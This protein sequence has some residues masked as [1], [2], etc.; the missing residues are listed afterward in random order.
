M[1]VKR[2]LK[3]RLYNPDYHKV[4][5]QKD[6]TIYSNM[7]SCYTMK[8]ARRLARRMGVGTEIERIYL[9]GKNAGKCTVFVYVGKATKYDH[10]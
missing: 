4:T 3:Y 10:H 5:H 7:E 2:K 6:C 1:K 8:K 9:T